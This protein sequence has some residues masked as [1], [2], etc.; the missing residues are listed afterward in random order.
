MSQEVYQIME[1]MNLSGLETQLA[2]Q[3][4]PLLSGIKISNLLIVDKSNKEAV[5]ETFQKTAI[6]YYIIYESEQKTTFLLYLE[7][8]IMKHLQDEAVRE[9][10]NLLGYHEFELQSILREISKRYYKYMMQRIAF[11][12]ELGLLLGYPVKDVVG[13]IENQ[14]KNFLYTGY[15][16]V[17]SNLSEAIQLFD[18]YNQAKEKVI[19]MISQGVSVQHILDIHY[20]S[21]Y[22]K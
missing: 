3:C 18:K 21:Q 10:M 6:S 5:I 7:N 9:T 15:W 12:H 4:A 19:R 1:A 20:S 2:L 8:E 13:F 11:P 22:Q 17:Y 14:G 16:K